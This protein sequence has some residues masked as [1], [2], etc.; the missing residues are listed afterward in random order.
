MLS[1]IASLSGSIVGGISSYFNKKQ[2]IKA[3]KEERQDRIEEAKVNAQIKQIEKES[4]QDYN[5]DKI[6]MQNMENSWKDE[7]ILII[8]LIPLVMSFIPSVQGYVIK[9]FD[10][11]NNTPDWYQ[12]LLIG[13][14]VVIYG[15]RGML[16]KF[17][18]ILINKWGK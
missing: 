15:M 2:E 16:T 17:M 4:E 8:F 18:Q 12:A 13:M 3:K 7:V 14:I 11:L 6:A 5:L 1:L 10:A 9:G